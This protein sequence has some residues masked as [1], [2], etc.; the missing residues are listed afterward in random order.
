MTSGYPDRRDF[1]A[2]FEDICAP[3]EVGRERL[4]HLLRC[5][6]V[7]AEVVRRAEQC[8]SEADA[9]EHLGRRGRLQSAAFYRAQLRAI[10]TA[11]RQVSKRRNDRLAT[12]PPTAAQETTR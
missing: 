9:D 3:M 7:L 4:D 10:T 8:L 2:W 6:E 11:K 12:P 5:E 1:D